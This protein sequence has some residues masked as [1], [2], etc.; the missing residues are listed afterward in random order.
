MNKPSSLGETRKPD[1]SFLK[2]PG[3]PGNLEMPM[4]TTNPKYPDAVHI[5]R[6]PKMA[7]LPESP[8]NV[9]SPVNIE[10]SE[11]PAEL[12]NF[13]IPVNPEIA[14]RLYS[15]V[16]Y[17]TGRRP[18]YMVIQEIIEAGLNTRSNRGPAPAEFINRLRSKGRRAKK[19]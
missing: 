14:G 19:P 4:I 13:N 7:I 17:D 1:L 16:F 10:L 6:P 12:V 9:E 15:E 2:K 11:K 18:L 8:L 5:P 3:I